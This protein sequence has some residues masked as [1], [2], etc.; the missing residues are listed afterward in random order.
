MGLIVPHT[1]DFLSG[2][3]DIG[4]GGQVSFKKKPN[5]VIT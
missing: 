2:Q 3:I 1:K 4:D 5:I